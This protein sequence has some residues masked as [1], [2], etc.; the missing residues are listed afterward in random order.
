MKR[1]HVYANTIV[2][3]DAVLLR[4]KM[5]VQTIHLR[6]HSRHVTLKDGRP[7]GR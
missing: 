4:K 6:S 5:P 7:A 2:R 3:A 1:R